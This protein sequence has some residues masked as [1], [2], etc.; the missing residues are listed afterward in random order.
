MDGATELGKDPP[1]MIT[2]W[3]L[4]LLA[5][6]GLGYWINKQVKN[7]K[8]KKTTGRAMKERI[9]REKEQDRLDCLQAARMLDGGPPSDRATVGGKPTSVPRA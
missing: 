1:T 6:G 8:N 2:L 3:V 9:A 4:G 5:I 7:S